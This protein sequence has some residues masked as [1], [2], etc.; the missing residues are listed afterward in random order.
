MELCRLQHMLTSLRNAKTAKREAVFK[1]VSCYRSSVRRHFESH[2]NKIWR[3]TCLC[4]QPSALMKP[5][6]SMVGL[7]R[8]TG[9]LW[10]HRISSPRLIRTSGHFRFKSKLEDSQLKALNH[11]NLQS[12]TLLQE[13]VNAVRN[14][15]ENQKWPEVLKSRTSNPVSL[16]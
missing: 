3:H 9:R 7:S 6:P 4:A 1:R 15:V 14:I 13:Q 11:Q 12:L 10:E 5:T 2:W 16:G 8:R